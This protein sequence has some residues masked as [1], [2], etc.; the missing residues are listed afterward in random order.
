[1]KRMGVLGLPCA[2]T[3]SIQRATIFVV[4][5]LILNLGVVCDGG[6]TSTFVRQI[7]RGLDMPL[8]SD[9]FKVPPGYNA[10]QQV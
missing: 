8:D 5:G 3:W 7:D 2:S 10:P 1:M 4:L 6:K 9:V